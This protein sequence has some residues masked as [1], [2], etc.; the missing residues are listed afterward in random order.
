MIFNLL[1]TTHMVRACTAE[2]SVPAPNARTGCP[3]IA[4]HCLPDDTAT[5]T[6]DRRRLAASPG[7]S[8]PGDIPAP[9]AGADPPLP[10][11][12]RLQALARLVHDARFLHRFRNLHGGTPPVLGFFNQKG[13]S[14]PPLATSRSPP[15]Q[16]PQMTGGPS[17]AATAAPSLR[18]AALGRCLFG[19]S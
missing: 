4:P 3:D 19:T 9:P 18:A 11:L 1:C 16:C 12:F 8:P 5:V 17:T 15:P 7:R 13:P 10:R 6:G 2:P 14:S